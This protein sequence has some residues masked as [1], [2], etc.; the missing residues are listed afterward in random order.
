MC[1]S[2]VVEGYIWQVIFDI[3]KINTG[4]FR[5]FPPSFPDNW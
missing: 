1:N 3:V 4:P 2:L 5:I